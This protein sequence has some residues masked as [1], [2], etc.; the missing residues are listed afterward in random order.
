MANETMKRPDMNAG[1]VY[2]NGPEP[3]KEVAYYDPNGTFNNLNMEKMRGTTKHILLP[4]SRWPSN[5]GTQ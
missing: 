1:R 2:F 3:P 4:G 5:Q